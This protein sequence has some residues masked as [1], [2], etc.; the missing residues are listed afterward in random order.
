MMRLMNMKNLPLTTLIKETY[1]NIKDSKHSPV[2]RKR[3]AEGF[4]PLFSFFFVNLGKADSKMRLS[5]KYIGMILGMMIIP[6]AANAQGVKG[7]IS[8]AHFDQDNATFGDSTDLDIVAKFISASTG[9]DTSVFGNVF[10]RYQTNWM[11]DYNHDWHQTIDDN[12]GPQLV[13]VGFD[14]YN[15]RFFCD[16]NE[17]VLR[18]GPVNVIII[19]PAFYNP[20]IPLEDSAAY[21]LFSQDVEHYTGLIETPQNFGTTVFPN[22]AQPLQLVFINSKYA[23]NIS[24]I[25]IMNNLGQIASFK[26]FADG[27]DSKGYVLP[28]ED[29]RPGIYH[30]HLVYSDNK[31]EVVKFIKN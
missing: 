23:K 18:T 21:Y 29:L 28:T 20:S 7:I 8:Y 1:N 3:G 27:E 22:P 17:N 12:P 26:E 16:S 25:S 15:C 10:F 4:S 14:V 11:W 30:I 5:L 9:N 31:S 19:W 24:K 2:Y 13:P 6:I